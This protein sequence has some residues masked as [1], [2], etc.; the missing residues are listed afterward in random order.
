MIRLLFL[1]YGHCSEPPMAS[2][3]MQHLIQ[4]AALTERL[5]VA[6]ACFPRLP[7]PLCEKGQAVL[8]T[9]HI[10]M[11]EDHH[12]SLEWKSYDQYDFILLLDKGQE[13]A[14]FN[15]LGGDVDEKIHLLSDYAASPVTPVNPYETGDFESAFQVESA[16]CQGLLAQLKSWIL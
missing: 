15:T 2:Y 12:F 5:S 3:L 10:P 16:G 11:E 14:L 7:S 6:S 4:E 9:H 13:G 8:R 1:S